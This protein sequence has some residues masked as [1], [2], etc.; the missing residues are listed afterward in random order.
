MAAEPPSL[1]AAPADTA[2]FVR[3]AARSFAKS[4]AA[5]RRDVLSTPSSGAT[6]I[7]P[8]LSAALAEPALGTTS[9]EP[10]L[11]AT[12]VELALGAR[13]GPVE[14]ALG[15][16]AFAGL[17]ANEV[18]R[19]LAEYGAPLPPPPYVEGA[20]TDAYAARIGAGS[21]EAG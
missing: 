2:P 15:S 1:G 7:A 10:T 9:V 17:L 3:M 11:G 12:P 19:A 13:L 4:L 5:V 21:E 16:D 6:P 8:T 18:R 14:P 20:T